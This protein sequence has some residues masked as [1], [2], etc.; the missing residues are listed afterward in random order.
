MFPAAVFSETDPGGRNVE[1]I[2]GLG[3]SAWYSGLSSYKTDLNIAGVNKVEVK[4]LRPITRGVH[5][6]LFWR[7]RYPKSPL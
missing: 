1:G 7:F 4:H 6:C 5:P 3:G 2:E